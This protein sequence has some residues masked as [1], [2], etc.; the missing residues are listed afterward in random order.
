MNGNCAG[1]AFVASYDE[2]ICL[3]SRRA[4]VLLFCNLL[5]PMGSGLA[6]V[7]YSDE[8]LCLVMH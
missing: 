2:V 7:A 6:F 5:L 4:L 1:L 3:E 8:V